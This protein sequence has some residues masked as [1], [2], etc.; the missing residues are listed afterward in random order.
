MKLIE[1]ITLITV[2]CSADKKM[3]NQLEENKKTKN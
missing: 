2:V 3:H 1:E